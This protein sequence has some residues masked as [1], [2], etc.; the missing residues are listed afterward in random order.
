M[1]KLLYTSFVLLFVSCYVNSGDSGPCGPG[2]YGRPTYTEKS[3][4]VAKL[5]TNNNNWLPDTLPSVAEFINQNNKIFVYNLYPKQIQQYRQD[6]YRKSASN[7]CQSVT[8]F[9]YFRAESQRIEYLCQYSNSLNIQLVRY[10]N[11]S[12]VD[13][14]NIEKLN[15]VFDIIIGNKTFRL[16]PDVFNNFGEQRFYNRYKNFDSVFNIDRPQADSGFIV[17]QGLYYSKKKGIIGFYFTNHVEEWEI[18]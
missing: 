14:L 17:P 12:N 7:Q 15:D 8:Y 1:Q 5:D 4:G 11:T 13:S 6:L 2:G 9:D 3:Y 16:E 10:K 18:R